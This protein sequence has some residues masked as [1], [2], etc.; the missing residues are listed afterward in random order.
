[1]H[2]QLSPKTTV[3]W[4]PSNTLINYMQHDTSAIL[5]NTWS[6]GVN[7]TFGWSEVRLSELRYIVW[8]A[9]STSAW[10]HV[11]LS[12]LICPWV[13]LLVAGTLSKAKNTNKNKTERKNGLFVILMTPY[14]TESSSYSWLCF[15]LSRMR[16]SSLPSW[17][18]QLHFTLQ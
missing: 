8:S 11:K 6:Y 7:A 15:H 5:P 2:W 12:K 17:S 16:R 1:M 13:N 4:Q 9:A 3:T 18:V 14:K 10:Q